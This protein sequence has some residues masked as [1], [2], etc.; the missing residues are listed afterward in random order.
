MIYADSF[1]FHG[2]ALLDLGP[3][4][5]AVKDAP[6]TAGSGNEVCCAVLWIWK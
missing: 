4:F 6:T 5:E 3:A 2:L 1:G